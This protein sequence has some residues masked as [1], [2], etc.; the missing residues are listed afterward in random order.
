MSSLDTETWQRA[1]PSGIHKEYLRHGGMRD[2]SQ[3][4]KYCKTRKGHLLQPESREEIDYVKFLVTSSRLA[5]LNAEQKQNSVG[6]RNFAWIDG[7]KVIS[8]SNWKAGAFNVSGPRITMDRN[9]FWQTS[10]DS[11]FNTTH[12]VI[13][14]RSFHAYIV[15][16][17]VFGGFFVAVIIG[18]LAAFTRLLM[19]GN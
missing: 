2:F 11:M 13:C 12:E 9:G 8:F 17:Y 4:Q 15:V 14:E 6:E 7:N 5:W 1:I 16:A 3:A 18:F 10:N 19:K